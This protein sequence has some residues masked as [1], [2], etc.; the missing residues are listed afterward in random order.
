MILKNILIQ[1]KKV[2]AFPVYLYSFKP[3][4]D[5]NTNSSIAEVQAQSI[6][7]CSPLRPR[8]RGRMEEFGQRRLG[9]YHV[10]EGFE[11][12]IHSTQASGITEGNGQLQV[13]VGTP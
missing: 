2:S 12:V 1:N 13:A 8:Q 5:A 6:A 4:L 7:F 3:S 9:L 10:R 11:E